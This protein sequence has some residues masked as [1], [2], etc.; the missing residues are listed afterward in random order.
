MFELYEPHDAVVY[1]CYEFRS[2][3]FAH[4][5]RLL[6]LERA[7]ALGFYVELVG[8]RRRPQ[9]APRRAIVVQLAGKD[10]LA[11]LHDVLEL[12]FSC[13]CVH[14]RLQIYS[15]YFYDTNKCGNENIKRYRQRWL[16][17]CGRFSKFFLA[18]V[19]HLDHSAHGFVACLERV[20]PHA[21][22]VGLAQVGLAFY[23]AQR[24]L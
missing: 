12:F 14:N 17:S 21:Q 23:H 20:A 2:Y 11:L 5:R 7:Y 8:E 1:Y 18:H 9:H 6:Y 4:E 10:V 24:L 19:Y 3:A 15:F 22:H 13:R 16:L